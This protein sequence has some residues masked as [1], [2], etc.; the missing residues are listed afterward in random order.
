MSAITDIWRQLVRRRLWPV[1]LLL[2]GALVAVPVL[3]SSS[4]APAPAAPAIPT[5]DAK[6]DVLAAKPVVETAST[7][8]ARR[9][10]LGARKDPFA[11]GRRPK[12]KQLGTGSSVGG[13]G[14]TTVAQTATAATTHTTGGG[15]STTVSAPTNTGTGGSTPT[16]PSTSYS[17]PTSST[18][19]AASAPPVKKPTYPLYSI[20]V[21]YGDASADSL[22]TSRINRLQPVPDETDPVAI[23]L[24]PGPGRRSAKFLVDASVTPQGDGTCLPDPADC[25]TVVLHEG[26]T[27]FFDTKDDTGAVTA[28]S[29]LDLVSITTKAASA[30]RAKAS[31]SGKRHQH[32]LVVADA[33]LAWAHDKAVGTVAELQK[34]A[35]KADVAQTARQVAQIVSALNAGA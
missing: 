19:P 15:T 5:T 12:V 7:T 29:E 16:G 2:L 4:P 17:P 21:R 9:H 18:P 33:A 26:D 6:D 1:A 13:T 31:A 22:P 23:Y 27:E 8:T 14:T 28:T 24:G 34:Q 3:L 11:P 20:V 30:R 35:W 25:Q 10:V 32:R